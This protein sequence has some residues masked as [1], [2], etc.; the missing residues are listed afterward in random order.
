MSVRHE[1]EEKNTSMVVILENNK[2][3]LKQYQKQVQSLIKAP[4]ELQAVKSK[5]DQQISDL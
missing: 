4:E 2:N 5:L 3:E 1:L